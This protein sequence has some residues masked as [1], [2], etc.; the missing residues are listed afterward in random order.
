[1]KLRKQ[2]EYKLKGER[3]ISSRRPIVLGER[4]I[5]HFIY[6]KKG[7]TESRIVCLDRDSFKVLWEY[8]YPFVVNNAVVS[9]NQLWLSCMDGWLIELDPETGQELARIELGLEKCGQCSHIQGDRLVIGGVQGSR[10]TLCVNLA[11]RA[12]EWSF[13]NGGHSYIPL[14]VDDRVYQCTERT[15]RCLGL[16]S[17][18]LLW[19][20]SEEGSYLFNPARVDDWVA[21]GGHGLVNVY[22]AGSGR[23]LQRIETGVRKQI[24]AIRAEGRV[25]YFGDSSG[26]F[27]AYEL[28]ARSG[29]RGEQ[30]L[31]AERLWCFESK[32]AIESLPEVY[33]DFVL[34]LN[35]DGKL[36]CLDRHSGEP[37]CSLNTKGEAGI[38]G[39]TIE[40]E[41]IFVS[42]GRGNAYR[43]GVG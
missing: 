9:G 19:E 27:Y 18:Q 3:N 12:V 14:I 7:F 25:M 34:L 33:G 40:G 15:I 1:M 2:L 28:V 8:K 42:V 22:D 30:M 38:S 16:N 26:L 43:V 21:V 36:I 13:D 37:L 5:A 20:A 32:G 24:W 4:L 29:P 41:G 6:D 35:D 10:S 23:L 39:V 31:D 11:S 17:G